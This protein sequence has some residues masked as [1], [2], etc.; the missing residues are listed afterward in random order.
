MRM[1]ICAKI[2]GLSLLPFC[3]DPSFPHLVIM[4]AL[5]QSLFPIC[6]SLSRMRISVLTKIFCFSWNQFCFHSTC[7]HFC[8]SFLL[9]T[10]HFGVLHVLTR[11]RIRILATV[12]CFSLL[13]FC[14][15]SPFSHPFI[16]F[17]PFNSSFLSV[18]FA[19]TDLN[20]DLRKILLSVFFNVFRFAGPAIL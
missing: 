19:D 11:M 4:F 3:L 1:S 10:G 6:H 13:S 17:C 12:F 15:H 16:V 2:F 20:A 18:A 7:I 14:F 5:F 9:S 8:I